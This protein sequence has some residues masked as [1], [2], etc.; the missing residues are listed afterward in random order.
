MPRKGFWHRASCLHSGRG[1]RLSGLS[2]SGHR[3]NGDG[4]GRPCGDGRGRRGRDDALLAVACLVF[5]VSFVVALW[6]FAA[7]ERPFAAVVV[8]ESAMVEVVASEVVAAVEWPLVVVV[9]VLVAL[10]A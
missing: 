10:A 5:A 9:E 2:D 3:R 8:A 7:A 6:V 4:R 1:H